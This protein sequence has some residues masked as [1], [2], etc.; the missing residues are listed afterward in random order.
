MD[1][2]DKHT[3]MAG[4]QYISIFTI[5][6][7]R[8][9]IIKLHKTKDAFLSAIQRA[10]T[11]A[12]HKPSILRSD[13]AG[14]YFTEPVNRYL[15]Q[16]HIKKETSNAREQFGNCR[17]ETLINALGKGMRVSRPS[18]RILGLRCHQLG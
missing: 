10:I 3:S 5:A 1:L 18:L 13:G 14:E 17:V 7:S 8:F 2:G 11:R 4:Y 16:E 15:L 6:K 9:V 12:G